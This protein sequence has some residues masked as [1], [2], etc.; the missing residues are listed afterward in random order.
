[1]ML[2]LRHV[3][4][5]VLAAVFVAWFLLLRPAALGGP[6]SYLWV[7]GS[8]MLPTLTTGDFVVT[9][10]QDH[11]SDGDILAYRVPKGDV[12]AGTIVIHRLV[13]G[14]ADKG[15]V[16]RG[17]NK[18]APDDWHPTRADV[19]GKLWIAIPGAGKYLQLLRTPT[20]FAPLVAGIVVF[21]ILLGGG[22]SKDKPSRQEQA[23]VTHQ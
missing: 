12:G 11:Y 2:R 7:S 16:L 1:M 17:D 18:P 20:V 21:F 5:L 6:A 10:H 3:P 22:G 8:S 14:S 15:Y 19:V 4:A 13:G 23:P 9:Q